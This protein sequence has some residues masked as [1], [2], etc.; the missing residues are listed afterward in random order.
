MKNLKSI[1]AVTLVSATLFSCAD[2]KKTQAEKAV[3]NYTTYVDSISNATSEDLSENWSDVESTYI[4]KKIE[5]ESALENLEDRT[6]YD[7]KVQSASAKYEEFKANLAAQR[8]QA[9]AANYKAKVR[10]SLFA[11]QEVGD[12]MNFAWVNK[13]NI[14]PTFETFVNTASDNKDNY[15]REEWDEIKLLWEALNTRKNTVENEG[16]SS[17][18]NLKIAGLKTRFA[19]FFKINRIGAKSE[20]NAEA[21]E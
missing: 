6:E 15:T 8:Q 9:E 7:G 18:D 14:L 10:S 20:E 2:E 5:A 1:I 3:N 13:D 17:S 19:T 11:G 12:D 16:L 4:A 21:K